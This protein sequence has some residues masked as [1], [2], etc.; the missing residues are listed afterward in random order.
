MT[1]D[2]LT[3]T[4]QEIRTADLVASLEDCWSAIRDHHGDVPPVVV[5]LGSGSPARAGQVMKWGHF[6]SMRWQHGGD[7][8]HEVLISGEGLARSPEEILTTLLHEAAHALADVRDIKDTSR[9]GRWHNK[10][11]AA[12][13]KELGL[14]VDKHDRFGWTVCNLADHTPIRYAVPLKA[15]ADVLSLYRHPEPVGAAKERENSNN[16]LSCLCDCGRK[17]RIAKSVF[18]I[19]PIVCAVCDG[20]FAPEDAGGA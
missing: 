1:V 8:V 18:E 2:D 7:L 12:L 17:I 10:H 20:A 3:R 5:I 6:A 13:A 14:T 15:L 19:G 4:C 9:Q 11:F 16:G